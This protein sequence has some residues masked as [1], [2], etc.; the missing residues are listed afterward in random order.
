MDFFKA[1]I[2]LKILL[3]IIGRLSAHSALISQWLNEFI[4]LNLSKRIVNPL[5]ICSGPIK[6]DLTTLTAS[7][8]EF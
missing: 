4:E 7:Y 5:E 1:S 8:R 3:K 2:F 6:P